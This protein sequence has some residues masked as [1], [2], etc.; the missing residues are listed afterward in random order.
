MTEKIHEVSIKII[1]DGEEVSCYDVAITD[2]I[3]PT[4]L[5]TVA[6]GMMEAFK[7]NLKHWPEDLGIKKLDYLKFT[8]IENP[9][10]IT[11]PMDKAVPWPAGISEEFDKIDK[12][13]T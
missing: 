1:A 11:F 8:K 13:D 2:G 10:P 12:E 3:C 5:K 7:I 4:L 9:A 6:F